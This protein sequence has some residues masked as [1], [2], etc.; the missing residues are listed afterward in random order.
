MQGHHHLQKLHREPGAFIVEIPS[1]DH[2][3]SNP[4]QHPHGNK[5]GMGLSKE[6]RSDW[7]RTREAFH[8]ERAKQE[9]IKRGLLDE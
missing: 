7:N 2:K 1:K 4:I 3:I 5:K 9:L 6:E 8:K